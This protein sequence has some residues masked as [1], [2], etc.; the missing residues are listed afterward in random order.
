L[1]LA[2][3]RDIETFV[4]VSTDEV[5][6]EA[7]D[8]EHFTEDSP[9]QPNNPY[10]ATKAAA[11]MLVRAYSKTYGLKTI[12]TRS[13]NNF[14]PNQFP[15]KL[16]P[17]SIIRVI[18]NLP[19]IIYGDGSQKREWIYVYDHIDALLQIISRGSADETYNIS[20]SYESKNIDI[21]KNIIAILSEYG[22]SGR[23]EFVKDRQSH[24]RRYSINS[25]K[26]RNNLDWKPSYDF[27]TALRNAIEWYLNHQNWWQDLDTKQ[28]LGIMD[29]PNK[30]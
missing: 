3:L 21:A 14:G 30:G 5:Y 13:C 19:I 22:I 28:A 15:E 16:I 10:S 24:D 26:L 4:Q 1:E 27:D 7:A 11:D 12:I 6:G 25:S 17:K 29:P 9:L 23:I 2:R 8:E 18:N 20:A